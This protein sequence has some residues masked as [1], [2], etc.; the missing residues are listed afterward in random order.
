MAT[1]ANP[2]T[3]ERDADTLGALA[4]FNDQQFGVCAEVVKSGPVRAG[5][6]LV[7]L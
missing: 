4:H 1:A 7:V 2:E 6:T 5:D 3:G